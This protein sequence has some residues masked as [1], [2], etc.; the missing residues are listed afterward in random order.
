MRPC[1]GITFPDAFGR[2][3]PNTEYSRLYAAVARRQTGR[4]PNMAG[5]SLVSQKGLNRTLPLSGRTPETTS[6]SSQACPNFELFESLDPIFAIGLDLPCKRIPALKF[7]TRDGD[8]MHVLG[9][10]KAE[11]EMARDSAVVAQVPNFSHTVE[12][13]ASNFVVGFAEHP[14]S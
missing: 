8:D 14:W 5:T 1:G 7:E 4:A 9:V 13:P 2:A 11:I 10:T 12:Y 3:K 6:S